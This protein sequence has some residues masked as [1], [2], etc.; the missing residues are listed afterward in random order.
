M[1]GQ[2]KSGCQ[3]TGRIRLRKVASDLSFSYGKSF[4][5]DGYHTQELVPYL[6]GTHF[7]F[8]HRFEWLHFESD[9]EYDPKMKQVAYKVKERLGVAL[10]PMDKYGYHYEER[11]AVST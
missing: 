1:I 4:T 6:A 3:L 10:N 5:K 7:D 8:G 2:E 11:F 9:D